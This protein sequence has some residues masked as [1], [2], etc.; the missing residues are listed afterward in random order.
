MDAACAILMPQAAHTDLVV[1]DC[2]QPRT[3][4]YLCEMPTSSPSPPSPQPP[5][6][7]AKLNIS[8]G[9]RPVDTSFPFPVITCPSGHVTHTF[10]STFSS[11]CWDDK[12]RPQLSNRRL[13]SDDVTR[14]TSFPLFACES[15][16]QRVP[17]TLLCDYKH[18][19]QDASDEGFC[20]Y[21]TGREFLHVECT[22]SRGPHCPKERK[23]W[24]N[25]FILLGKPM[26]TRF[27]VYTECSSLFR[28][29]K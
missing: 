2:V 12:A 7:K 16:G 20:T 14:V 6:I 13:D 19:C 11:H 10:L 29:Q 17:Y 24:R 22:F 26:K 9:A 23:V 28:Q 1:T 21:G 27:I 18:D 25:A 8:T 15:G 5:T 3:P 4:F